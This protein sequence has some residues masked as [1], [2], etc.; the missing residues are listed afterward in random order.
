M[1]ELDAFCLAKLE[2]FCH[3]FQ[4]LTGKTNYFLLAMFCAVDV[5][6]VITMIYKGAFSSLSDVRAHYKVFVEPM[7]LF[8]ESIWVVIALYISFGGWKLLENKGYVRIENGFANPTKNF[9][10]L[11]LLTLYTSI[12]STGLHLIT[13]AGICLFLI[14]NVLFVV[15]LYL[16]SCDPL[17]P[18]KGK[19][20]EYIEQLSQQ[21][22]RQFAQQFAR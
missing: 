10:I 18:Q 12:F 8:L 15:I 13:H 21:L 2:K 6:I 4:K 17:P 20:R 19:L 11:R 16:A 3:W 9:V 14:D 5:L 7:L 1:Y 22:S